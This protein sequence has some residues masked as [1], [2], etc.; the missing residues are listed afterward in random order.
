[1]PG[2]SSEGP[3]PPA[4]QRLTREQRTAQLLD[5][6][7]AMFA[8]R[9][10]GGTSLASLAQAAGISRPIIY[11]HFG[12]KDGIYLACLR[13]ARHMLDE[14]VLNA[15]IAVEDIEG[16]LRAGIDATFAFIEA[17]PARW[18]VVYNGVAVTGAVAEEA[19]RLRLATVDQIAALIEAAAPETPRRKVEAFA[20][21]LSGAVEETERWWRHSPG[22]SRPEAVGHL[23]TFAWHGVSELYRWQR[24]GDDEV[25]E[26]EVAG[27]AGETGGPGEG[28]DTAGAADAGGTADTAGTADAGEAGA[29]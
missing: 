3:A 10:Y 20:H 8:E 29:S 21:A 12:S 9:G 11:A 4:R 17:N 2:R 7:E 24:D 27:E 18:S 16:R 5:V 1:M 15:V 19:W 14:A 23:T 25:D 26:P 6:A 22:M 28:D 13:R